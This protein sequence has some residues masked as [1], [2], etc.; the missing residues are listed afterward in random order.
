MTRE[1]FLVIARRR[2][3][4]KL[5]AAG[6]PAPDDVLSEFAE[7]AALVCEDAGEPYEAF[8]FDKFHIGHLDHRALD[9][10]VELAVTNPTVH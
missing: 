7:F 2:I 1:Q 5:A 9:A 8:E 3:R 4:D 6:T 10:M